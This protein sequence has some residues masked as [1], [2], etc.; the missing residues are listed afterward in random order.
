MVVASNVGMGVGGGV[1]TSVGR[2]VG[3]GDGGKHLGSQN[4]GHEAELI[5]S[6]QFVAGSSATL[7]Q[8]YVGSL[9]H[10]PRH[11]FSQIAGQLSTASSTQRLVGSSST[12][13][14]S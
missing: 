14:Q 10:G 5:A 1:K 2:R 7:S 13:A 3:G 8:S 12:A 4:S 11:S 6:R 9:S